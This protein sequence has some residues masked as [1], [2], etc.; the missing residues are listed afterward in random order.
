MKA[1]LSNY[2]QSPRKVRLVTDSIK[3]KRVAD[4]LILLSYL[5]KRASHA[6]KKLLASAEAN[7]RTN[8]ASGDSLVVKNIT[9]NEGATFRRF[10]P[11]AFGRATP[12]RKRTSHIQ[13]ELGEVLASPSKPSKK[14]KEEVKAVTEEVKQK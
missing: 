4:A 5:P 6:I 3:G 7:A 13:V 2:R 12:I 14:K 10:M 9:V 1:S 11:R 8:G